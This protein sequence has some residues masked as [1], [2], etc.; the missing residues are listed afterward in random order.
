MPSRAAGLVLSADT[1]PVGLVGTTGREARRPGGEPGGRPG[2][3]S[4]P[5]PGYIWDLAA[6]D[7]F[8]AAADPGP[9]TEAPG[10]VPEDGDPGAS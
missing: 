8:P 10:A 2:S 4:P 6:T 3:G 7:V 5:N 9:Q 1:A